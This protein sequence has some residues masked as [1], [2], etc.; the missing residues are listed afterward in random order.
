MRSA[1]KALD[2]HADCK[3][4]RVSSVWKTPPWG[5]TDQPD[6]LNA[7]AAVSTTLEPRAFLNLCLSVE[8]DLKRVRDQRW[9]PRSI[10]I[11]ILFFGDRKIEEPGLTV[12]H[13]RIAERAFVLVPLAEIAPQLPL[14]GI[15]IADLAKKSDKAG[16]AQAAPIK[17]HIRKPSA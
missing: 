12:P 13:P 8:T 11:D 3:V 7:C 9:G 1:L 17:A 2:T 14:G 10:D 15:S 5:V 6:F 4:L 16:M